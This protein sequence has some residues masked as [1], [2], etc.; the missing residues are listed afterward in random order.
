MDDTHLFN[1]QTEEFGLNLNRIEYE[2]CKVIP[3]TFF[4]IYDNCWLLSLLLTLFGS[5]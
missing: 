5:L 4:T 1:Q 3:I 2:Q